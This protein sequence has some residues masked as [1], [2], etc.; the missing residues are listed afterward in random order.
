MSQIIKFI[1]AFSLCA[2]AHVTAH[3]DD[4]TTD[5]AYVY[6]ELKSQR[7]AILKDL[8][9]V[10]RVFR[11]T[12]IDGDCEKVLIGYITKRTEKLIQLTDIQFETEGNN[13]PNE[14]NSAK[15]LANQG[16]VAD[17]ASTTLALSQGAQELNPLLGSAPG[18]G[19]L[20]LVGLGRY[21]LNQSLAQSAD[22]TDLEK[23][24]SLCL[25]SGISNGAA[26]NNVLLLLSGAGAVPIVVGIVTAKVQRDKCL[27]RAEEARELRIALENKAL[28]TYVAWAKSQEAERLAAID[29]PPIQQVTDTE[30]TAPNSTMPIGAAANSVAAL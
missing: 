21:Q 26:A 20:A 14:T 1:A 12:C 8:P 25:I 24:K 2:S 5:P 15:E 11:R 17:M 13:S 23:V 6:G 29:A 7:G 16:V 30:A 28:Q 3:A 18:L 10:S 9:G 4:I 19:T 22:S 27:A